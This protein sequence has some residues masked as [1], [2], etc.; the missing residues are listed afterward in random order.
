ME[1]YSARYAEMLEQITIRIRSLT[2]DRI[3]HGLRLTSLGI[4]A[5]GLAF[6]ALVFLAL[7]VFGALEIPLTTAGAWGVLGVLLV[8]AGTVLWMKRT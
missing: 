6:S 4:M 3:S 8:G 5:A 2:V 1:E 7:A